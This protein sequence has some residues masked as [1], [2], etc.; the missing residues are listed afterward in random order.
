MFGMFVAVL[1]FAGFATA[2]PTPFEINGELRVRNENDNRDFNSA[3]DMK[4]FNLMRTRV[5]IGVHPAQDMN[6]FV[7]VQDSRVQGLPNS[8]T[9]PGVQENGSLDLHQGFFQVDNLGYQGLGLKAGRME[10]RFGNERLIGVEDWDN[11][12]RS[13]DGIMATVNN[14]RFSGQLLWANLYEG[15]DTVVGDPSDQNKS[16]ARMAAGFGSIVVTPNANAD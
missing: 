3:T 11:V 6:V 1:A 9:I 13:F 15:D 7:Q 5:G 12:T 2:D 10:V 14:D 4:S 8:T 16:D